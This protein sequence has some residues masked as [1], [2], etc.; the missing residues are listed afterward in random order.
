MKHNELDFILLF[1]DVKEAWEGPPNSLFYQFWV[2]Y[3][4]F[5]YSE[6]KDYIKLV[7]I[8][9]FWQGEQRNK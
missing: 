3:L 7:T 2:Q 1:E 6:Y 5:A 4:S 9:P 8:Q